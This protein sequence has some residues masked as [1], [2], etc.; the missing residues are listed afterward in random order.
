[1]SHREAYAWGS[2][3]YVQC[4]CVRLVFLIRR[5]AVLSDTPSAY[6]SVLSQYVELQLPST[7]V[8]GCV[9]VCHTSDLDKLAGYGRAHSYCLLV[10]IFDA[11]LG[12]ADCLFY[13]FFCDGL[14]NKFTKIINK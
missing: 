12:K 6:H 9:R 11:F 13:N 14:A 7:P 5:E 10:Y 4:E 3:W 8:L 2:S 1:M